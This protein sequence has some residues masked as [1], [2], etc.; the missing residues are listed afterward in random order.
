MVSAINIH[1]SVPV[2]LQIENHLL[3]AISSG[4]LGVGAQLPAVKELG[5]NLGINVNTVIKAYRDLEVMGFISSRR[6]VGF[7]VTKG[8]ITR[9]R[10]LCRQRLVAKAHELAQEAKAA[11]T[12]KKEL[13]EV[14][15]K[16]LACDLDPYAEVPNSVMALARRRK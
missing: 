9:C 14:I 4:E 6:G 5:D 11:G 16:S 10:D 7:H 1:S 12:T 8:A 15:G 3:F 2:Y 13:V